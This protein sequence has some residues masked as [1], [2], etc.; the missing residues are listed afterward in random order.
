MFKKVSTQ[1]FVRFDDAHTNHLVQQL[2][3]EIS[4]LEQ[5]LS[6]L[7]QDKNSVDFT[8]EQTYKEMLNSRKGQ[9]RNIQKQQ[10]PHFQ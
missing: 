9:L 5:K 6:K 3:T 1:Q 4:Q 7:H 8:T 2:V 10:G